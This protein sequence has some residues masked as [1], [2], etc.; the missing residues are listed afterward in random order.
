MS[1]RRFVQ[2]NGELVEVSLDYQASPRGADEA[3]WNDRAYQDMNDPRFRSRS[4]HRQYMKRHGLSTMDDY[5]QQWSK[6][7]EQRESYLTKGA[8]PTRREDIVRALTERTRG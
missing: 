2:I 5:K 4:Q 6:Q 1:R 8:D 7:R 3:L